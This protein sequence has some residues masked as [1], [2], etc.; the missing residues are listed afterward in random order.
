MSRPGR[1][2]ASMGCVRDAKDERGLQRHED[3]AALS[4]DSL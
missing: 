1:G 4:G 3:A 2:P